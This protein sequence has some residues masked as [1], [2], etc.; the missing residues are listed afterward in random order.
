MF[1][2]NFFE[3]LWIYYQGQ[4]LQAPGT[5]ITTSEQAIQ[6]PF[7][8]RDALNTC[9][10]YLDVRIYFYFFLYFS[11]F[12]ILR[13]VNHMKPDIRSEAASIMTSL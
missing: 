3:K 6:N 5:Q 11:G 7:V 8:F 13:P 9:I 1:H 4:K 12:R 10:D 2:M